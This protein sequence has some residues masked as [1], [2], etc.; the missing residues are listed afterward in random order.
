[1]A[2]W[3]TRCGGSGVGHHPSGPVLS[4]KRLARQE[5]IRPI[6]GPVKLVRNTTNAFLSSVIFGIEQQFL[7]VL[8]EIADRTAIA[9]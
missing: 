8:G 6:S 3:L 4:V 5:W 7:T 2:P 9:Q 1:M